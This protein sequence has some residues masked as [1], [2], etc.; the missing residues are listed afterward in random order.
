MA[1]KTAKPTTHKV[2]VLTSVGSNMFEDMERQLD[3]LAAQGWTVH[4]S[5]IEVRLGQLTVYGWA[6]K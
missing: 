3:A 6:T 5:Q 4:L 2:L 1:T